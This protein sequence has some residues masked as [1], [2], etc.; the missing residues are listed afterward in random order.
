[1]MKGLLGL[2]IAVFLGVTGYEV[3]DYY[4]SVE[5]PQ[6]LLTTEDALATD[7]LVALGSVSIEHAVRLETAFMGTPD[8]AGAAAQGLLTDTPFARLQSAGID[9]RS[10]L[11]H[12]VF[13]LY[14]GSDEEPGYA[15]AVLGN[16]DKTRVLESLKNEYEVSPA[17]KRPDRG[18]A[19]PQTGYRQ[20]QVV[21]PLDPVC[22]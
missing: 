21:A 13:A 3:W 14:L 1:M 12:M 19:D 15:V 10:D 2:A 18:L 7:E 4:V 16:F 6:A 11:R 22:Q 17:A 20:L 8:T 5:H 9:P